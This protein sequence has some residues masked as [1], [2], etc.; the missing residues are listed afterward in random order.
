MSQLAVKEE[1]SFV[2]LAMLSK[3]YF[4]ELGEERSKK[5]FL[6]AKPGEFK[7]LPDGAQDNT[8]FS[9]QGAIEIARLVAKGIHQAEVHSLLSHLI[10]SSEIS[11]ITTQL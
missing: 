8:H 11:S 3:A 6:W 4:E 7:N 2:D 5:V 1:V 9:E 10:K